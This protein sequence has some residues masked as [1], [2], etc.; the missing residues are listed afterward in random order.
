MNF[1]DAFG[2]RGDTVAFCDPQL[3]DV[4]YGNLASAVRD[5]RERLDQ[6]AAGQGGRLLV[7]VEITP[8]VPVIAAYLGAL[9]GGHP[10]ILV[11]P[12]A[13]QPDTDIA[14]R[15]KPNVVLG[16]SGDKCVLTPTDAGPADMHPDLRLLLSTSGTTGDPRLVRLSAEAVDANAGSIAQYL[17]LQPQDVGITALPLFYSFGMSVLHSHLA[18]GA[19]LVL[20]DLSAGEPAFAALYRAQAV[21][22]LQ[23]VPHQIDLLQAKGFDFASSAGLRLVAQAGGR[24]APDKV[25]ELAALGAKTGWGFCVMYGQTEAAPRMSYLPPADAAANPDCIGRAIPGGRLF[26]S[27]PNGQ[28]ITQPGISGELIYDGP[29]VM[30]GYADTRADLALG[31]EVHHLR[32]GD[33]AE[34]NQAGYFRIIG[35]E[36]RIAKLFGLRI[37]LDQVEARLTDAGFS[38]YA[39]SVDDSLVVMT[40]DSTKA[41][42][43]ISCLAD[44]F[45]LPRSAIMV[46]GMADVPILR[47][48]KTDVAEIT[49]RANSIAAAKT[50]APLGPLAAVFADALRRSSVGP[51]DSF[52]GL[53]GDSLAFLHVQLALEERLGKAPEGWEHMT[54]AAIENLAP[55]T[56]ARKTMVEANVWLR[57]VAIGCVVFF[58]TTHWMTMGGTWLLIILTGYSCARFQKSS[59][60]EGAVLRVAKNMLVP[61]V[62]LYFL[63][64]LVYNTVRADIPLGMYL[65]SGNNM[66]RLPAPLLEPLWFVSLY[67]QLTLAVLL[68]ATIP[69][70]RKKIRTMPFHFGLFA[71]FATAAAS[72]AFQQVFAFFDLGVISED[73]LSTPHMIRV[74]PVC[75]PF[76]FLGWSAYFADTGLRKALTVAALGAVVVSFPNTWPSFWAIAVGG[77]LLLLLRIDLSLPKAL[78]RLMQ[79]AASASLFIYLVHNFV[80]LSLR[81]ALPSVGLEGPIIAVLITL[82]LCLFAGI[83]AQSIFTYLSSCLM[84]LLRRK[85]ATRIVRL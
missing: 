26:I 46:G 61:I 64:L 83:G 24:A 59:L 48:G 35:R 39:A 65:L 77:A 31:R 3:G 2:P 41:G 19:R 17:D 67:A 58:H 21:T 63:M 44:G 27:G 14:R 76:L 23:L 42:Q 49:A 73:W 43:I 8:R 55:A 50:A 79:R 38:G 57:L 16:M 13:S 53:G 72:I 80:V 85:T 52:A 56:A 81:A 11:A 75:L 15:Y 32:T 25:R 62:P 20:T 68:L 6:L 29:N 30:L 22:N 34:R 12:G 7:S 37:S 5:W 33:I 40:T 10:V 36:K 45:S 4:T 18:A 69:T 66:G 9:S 51:S 1:I 82:P 28:E 70:A 60:G 84:R 74:L 47:S 78:S 71:T 54:L